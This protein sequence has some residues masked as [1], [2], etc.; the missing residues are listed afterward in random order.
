MMVASKKAE[1][2]LPGTQNNTAQGLGL[3]KV[4]F[5]ALSPKVAWHFAA[6][7]EAF[8]ATRQITGSPV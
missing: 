1:A 2:E 4:D 5:S 6:S 7:H 8:Y 3:G